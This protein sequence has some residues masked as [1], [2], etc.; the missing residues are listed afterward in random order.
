MTLE[1]QGLFVAEEKFRGAGK[2]N[3]VLNVE[4]FGLA[5]FIKVGGE[6]TFRIFGQVN[7]NIAA[8]LPEGCPGFAVLGELFAEIA[9]DSVVQRNHDPPPYA[10]SKNLSKKRSLEVNL[11]SFGAWQVPVR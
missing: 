7:D 5:K 6:I 3:R 2:A 11:P 8:L 4:G 1:H 10:S 9:F